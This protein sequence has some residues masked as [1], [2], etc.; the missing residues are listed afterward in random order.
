[1]ECPIQAK[2]QRRRESQARKREAV[3]HERGFTRANVLAL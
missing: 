1:M 2:I 3:I